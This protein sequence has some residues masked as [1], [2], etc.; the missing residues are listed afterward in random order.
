MSSGSRIDFDAGSE[1]GRTFGRSGSE[2]NGGI[3]WWMVLI[4]VEAV[5]CWDRWA[6]LGGCSSISV[7]SI[8]AEEVGS[9]DASRLC[10][11]DGPKVFAVPSWTDSSIRVTSPRCGD[12]ILSTTGFEPGL[13]F[14]QCYRPGISPN[15][16][17]YSNGETG[18]YP[19]R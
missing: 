9:L 1:V 3:V 7:I 19:V 13:R 17:E 14:Q 8:G 11:L 4:A 6:W 15:P 12:P 16:L 5:A 18:K 2:D 10:S